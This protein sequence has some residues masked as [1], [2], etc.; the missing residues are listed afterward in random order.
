MFRESYCGYL[1]W[2]FCVVWAAWRKRR[3]KNIS[4]SILKQILDIKRNYQGTSFRKT[5]A[6]TSSYN[7]ELNRGAPWHRILGVLKVFFGFKSEQMNRRKFLWRWLNTEAVS[8]LRNYL[9]WKLWQARRSILGKYHYCFLCS[10][11]R[12]Y[13]TAST[14]GTNTYFPITCQKKEREKKRNGEEKRQLLRWGRGGG[15]K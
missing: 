2:I 5:K 3:G 6:S 8:L 13:T 10:Y 11:T 7:T 15:G 9:R 1:W 4:L 14:L 12:S